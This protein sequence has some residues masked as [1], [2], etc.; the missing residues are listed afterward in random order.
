MASYAVLG[1]GGVGGFVAGALSRSGED[2]TVVAGEDTAAVIADRGIRVTSVVLG[3]FTATP[4]A[5]SALER[6]VDVLFV[7]TKAIG[8]ENALARIRAGAETV[9]PLLNGRDHMEALRA[10][11]GDER[12]AA[13]VIR[14]ESDR[15]APGQVVQSSPQV[16]VDLASD[17][18]K[19]AARLPPIA[20]A[21]ERAG[22]PA[23]TGQ[24]E[25]QILWSKLVRLNALSA[26]TT[27]SGQPIGYIRS[28]PTWRSVM[29]DC[30]EE[31]AAAATAE[32][33]NIDPGATLA[34]LDQAHP[35]LGSSMQRDIQAGRTPELDAIQ[36]SVMRAAARHGLGCPTVARLASEIAEKAGIAPPRAG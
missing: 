34:E 13:G 36:G 23:R 16:R 17:D 25:A 9:V 10:R 7:A 30:I 4:A 6:P 8:L 24:S 12:V 35:G 20:G 33:A 1:P 26:T 5:A 2:V 14:I 11:F 3:E 21:L 28:D 15:P 27:V 18:E 19:I 29:I 22:I 32:G 31:A